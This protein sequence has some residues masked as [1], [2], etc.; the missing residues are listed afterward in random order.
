MENLTFL[1]FWIK[2]IC[3]P[4]DFFS[5]DFDKEKSPYFWF[6]LLI[7]GVT[8]AM[9]R[10][11][12]QFLKLELGKKQNVIAFLNHWEVYWILAVVSGLLGGLLFYYFGGW[13]FN[14][15]VKWSEGSPDI[16]ASRF[17]Y[18]Y[19]SFI[20]S[21]LLFLDAIAGTITRPRPYLPSENEG[22][23]WDIF[24]ALAIIA[25]IYYS[26]YVSYRGATVIMKLDKW[27]GRVWFVVLPSIF[28]T[29]AYA[30][31]IAAFM[32]MPM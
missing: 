29:L 19:S 7:Y 11:D 9:D 2:L 32:M 14:L 27:R 1:E 21:F 23:N 4:G 20:P 8:G 22:S 5:K 13:F 30:A 31:I 12:R 6:V 15:R 25:A 18:L 24:W 16:K 10:I 26:I 3:H 28:Y 17:I